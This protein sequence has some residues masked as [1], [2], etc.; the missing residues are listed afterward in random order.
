MKSDLNYTKAIELLEKVSSSEG[1]LASAQ[2]IS[3]YKRVWARDGVI[4][5]LAALASGEEKLIETFRKTLETLATTLILA[6]ISPALIF[7]PALIYTS[8]IIPLV[9]GLI[10]TSS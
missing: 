2:N 4:C 5:G 1:F 10:R 3:N 7:S 8:S 9:F 6:I